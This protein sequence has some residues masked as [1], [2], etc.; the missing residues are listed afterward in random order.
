MPISDGIYQCTQDPAI[1]L[2]GKGLQWLGYE[3]VGIHYEPGLALSNGDGDFGMFG[4]CSR[5]LSEMLGKDKIALDLGAGL[6]QAAIPLAAAGTQ[7]IA[8]DIS[9]NMLKV[10]VERASAYGILDRNLVCARMN[11]YDLKIRDSSIDAVI[12][13]DMLHQVDQPEIV[14]DE[15]RRVLKPDGIYVKYRSKGLALDEAQQKSNAEGHRIESDIQHFYQAL[16]EE[17]GYGISP[18]SSWQKAKACIDDNFGEPQIV[19]T[20][21]VQ[22]WTGDVHFKLYKTKMRASGACQCI[23]DAVHDEAWRK[24]EEYAIR[25]F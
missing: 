10:L 11:A 17:K 19:D 13:I 18:F 5:K 4:A 12:E 16:T 22:N 25:R 1:S 15:I 3:N 20:D 21:V 7:T 14:V 9:Q 24:T 6:G 2:F 8:V 23:P